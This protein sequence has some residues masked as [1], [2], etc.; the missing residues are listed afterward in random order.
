VLRAARLAGGKTQRQVAAE[1]GVSPGLI[2]Q[3]ETGRTRP[4]VATLLAIAG[5]LDLSVDD[6]FA[7]DDSLSRPPGPANARL[8][9]MANRMRNHTTSYSSI[10]A[11][12][13]RAGR[14]EVITLEDGVTWELL[15]PEIDHELTFMLVTYPAGSSSS[16]S[17]ELL[18]HDDFEYFHILRGVLHVKVGFEETVLEAD[19]SMSFDSSR[20]HR[21][22]NRSE[23]A[24]AAGL[25][26]VRS[27][28]TNKHPRRSGQ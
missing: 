1:A 6:L 13:V 17:V 9:A 12:V 19:D 2:G 7:E 14:G 5:V 28:P 15:T 3:I 22:V 10:E 18:R 23:T 26:C 8:I 20:P 11:R 16:S 25:W 27:K 4:S 24:T 21:F